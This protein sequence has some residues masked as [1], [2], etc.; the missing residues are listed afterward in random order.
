[1]GG[2]R[3][4]RGALG[5]R[6]SR[7]MSDWAGLSRH[8]PRPRPGTWG[9]GES[10]PRR[11]ESELLEDKE[12]AHSVRGGTARAW[13]PQQREAARG[14]QG[15]GAHN[16]VH[17]AWPTC[18]RGCPAQAL[19]VVPAHHDVHHVAS[20]AGDAVA[21]RVKETNVHLQCKFYTG[22]VQTRSSL[23]P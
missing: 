22:G 19:P 10:C 17:V 18:P 21:H 2:P 15:G 8:C 12:G 3:Q 1:M 20:T 23:P 5:A 16:P 4:S 13:G 7:I 14:L 6:G 9:E 11:G